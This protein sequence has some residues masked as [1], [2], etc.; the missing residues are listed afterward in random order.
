M[1]DSIYVL[2]NGDTTGSIIEKTIPDLVL[3]DSLAGLTSVQTLGTE[4]PLKLAVNSTHLFLYDD[5]LESIYKLPLADLENFTA[6]VEVNNSDLVYDICVDD[7]YLYAANNWGGVL[8]Y[9]LVDLSFVDETLTYNLSGFPISF[10]STNAVSSDGTYLYVTQTGTQQ[11]IKIAIS[12][13]PSP[14]LDA[15]VSTEPMDFPSGI[16]YSGGYVFVSDH[17]NFRVIKFNATTLVK[18]SEIGS[19]G[20]G[21]D[22]F[23]GPGGVT[24]DGTSIYVSD[25]DNGR[26]V[27]R[28]MSLV[29]EAQ[30]N[31][32]DYYPVNC[33]ITSGGNLYVCDPYP[34]IEPLVPRVVVLNPSTFAY[35]SEVDSVTGT[36]LVPF[37]LIKTICNDGEFVY[38]IEYL[39]G[40]VV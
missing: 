11:V 17:W 30:S 6:M 33:A 5:S 7:N 8:R 28:S 34:V 25:P 10:S 9:S 37:G 18:D 35:I 4:L 19:N 36:V 2:A 27:R 24:T 40:G 26:V 20:P 15:V 29:Y 12:D 14:V 31:N 13:M 39:P 32:T 38:F 1:A 21:D 3:V 23:A 22:Q 16:C